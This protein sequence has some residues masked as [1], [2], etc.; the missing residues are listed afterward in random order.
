MNEL[1]KLKAISAESMSPLTSGLDE[2]SLKN[3]IETDPLLCAYVNLP[4]KSIF[5]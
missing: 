5:Y 3:F 1:S 4:I 2:E